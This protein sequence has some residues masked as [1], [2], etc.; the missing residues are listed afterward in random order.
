[1]D[2]LVEVI[3]MEEATKKKYCV[4]LNSNLE[5]PILRSFIEVLVRVFDSDKPQDWQLFWSAVTSLEKALSVYDRLD[6]ERLV[7]ELERI[8]P[9]R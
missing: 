5:V 6:C 2:T 8:P 1:M 3:K 7:T 9:L 4:A